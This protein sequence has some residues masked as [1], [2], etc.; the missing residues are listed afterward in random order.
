MY[1]RQDYA[2]AGVPMLP[3]VFGDRVAA[4]VILG[5]TV[6]LVLLALLP[7]AWGAGAFYLA[8][9]AAG[10]AYFLY[11]SVLLAREPT[12]KNAIRNFLASLLQLTLLLVGAIVDGAVAGRLVAY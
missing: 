5:H 9:A 2:D 10:G 7:V 8:C 3:V 11:R 1:Y 4:H 12:Q 6:P